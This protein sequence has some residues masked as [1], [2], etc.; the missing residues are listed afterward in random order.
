MRLGIRFISKDLHA[1][2]QSFVFNVTQMSY[3][4]LIERVIKTFVYIYILKQE[5]TETKPGYIKFHDEDLLNK[6]QITIKGC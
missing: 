2:I 4:F 3:Y 5:Q 6:K 1:N